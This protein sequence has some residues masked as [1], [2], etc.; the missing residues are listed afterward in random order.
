M[1]LL[2]KVAIVTGASS[3]I[4][5]AVARELVSA[6][7]KVVVTARRGERIKSLCE[8]LVEAVCLEADINDPETPRKL[9]NQ[10]VTAFGACDVVIN[11]AGI[12][13]T[14]P[15]DKIDLDR[16]CEMVRVNVE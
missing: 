12:L 16:V 7:M 5:A 11:N 8:E 1:T 9:I 4:G 2:D 10:A 3:G 13:E 14:G 15:I 6:G